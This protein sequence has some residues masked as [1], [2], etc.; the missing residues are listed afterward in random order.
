MA[1][2]VLDQV[3]KVLPTLGKA[4]SGSFH[5]I[6]AGFSYNFRSQFIARLLNQILNILN[7]IWLYIHIIYPTL[8]LYNFLDMAPEPEIKGVKVWGS[9]GPIYSPTSGFISIA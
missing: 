6:S 5:H 2:R 8:F 1:T 3:L 9:G 7:G 4:Q